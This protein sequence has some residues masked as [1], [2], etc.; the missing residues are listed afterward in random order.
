MPKTK[1]HNA[2]SVCFKALAVGGPTIF[3]SD[4]IDRPYWWGDW[5]PHDFPLVEVPRETDV[6]VVGAGYAGLSCA[7]ELARNARSVVV[8][9]ADVP[10]IG[11]STRNGGQV[12]GGVNVGKKPSGG[13]PSD[14]WKKRE[15]AMLA[16]AAEAYRLFERTLDL[17]G[18]DCSYRRNGRITALWT[19]EHLR[20]WAERIPLLNAQTGADIREMSPDEMR[21][22]LASDYY[23]GGVFVS[24]AGHI[25]PAK[26][27]RGLLR[28]AQSSGAVVCSHAPAS[29]IERRGARFA[30]TTERG[31]IRAREVVIATN[32]YTK[33][34][35]PALRRRVV[36]V[37]SHQIC[38]EEL[39]SDLRRS[40]IPNDRAVVETRRVT[41]YY[42]ISPDGKRLLFGGRARFYPLTA[43]Q[44]A[45]V[46]HTQ[47]IARFPQLADVK[48]SHSWGGCVALTFDFLPHIGKLDGVHY[49]LGCNGSG[50][51][52]MSYLGH[53]VARQI[54]DRPEAEPSSYAAPLQTHPLYHG[55]P[56]FMPLIGTYFQLRDVAD[57]KLSRR[58]AAPSPAR[59]AA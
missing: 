9:E 54:L 16:E 52:M 11:A 44:S 45:T 21:R 23:A 17:Y 20:G 40:L 28:A 29:K 48:V 31:T 15:S 51:T 24:R 59:S 33:M 18:I 35:M 5:N 32:G 46:L 1:L 19:S 7:L 10:G 14:L 56:W 49:A 42:C 30:V 22:E 41:N 43:R 55:R 25:D 2:Y 36:P 27:F 53:K 37:T 47:M 6:V 50:V 3:P 26:Y 34:L 12:T 58:R 38:T 8:L 57:R 39:P 4:F 13:A